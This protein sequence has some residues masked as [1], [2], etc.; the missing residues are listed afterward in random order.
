MGWEGCGEERPLKVGIMRQRVVS[1]LFPLPEDPGRLF[2]SILC[3]EVGVLVMLVSLAKAVWL[4][5]T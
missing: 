5:V 1:S 4:E 3:G 2:P